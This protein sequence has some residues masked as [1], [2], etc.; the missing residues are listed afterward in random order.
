MPIKGIYF[1]GFIFFVALIFGLSYRNIV[2]YFIY[3]PD[4]TIQ[5]NPSDWQLNYQEVWFETKDRIKLHGWFFP[6]SEGTPVILF[7]HGNAGNMSHR[8]ENIRILLQHRLSVFIFDYR[9]YG[10]SEG[11]PS[12][13]GLYRDGQAAYDH[14][15]DALGIPPERIIL[16]GRSLGA[17]VAVDLSLEKETKALIIES[18]FTSTRDM[19]K[20]LFLFKWIAPLL[21]TH[22]NNLEKITR[23]TVPKL[24]IHGEKDKIVPFS[25]GQTLFRAALQPKYFLPL[26]K[27]GHNN[28][29]SMD[30]ITYFKTLANFAQALNI[31][32]SMQA[33]GVSF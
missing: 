21:P 7:C 33:V 1:M 31:S 29:W 18:A 26:R 27:A 30:E 32:Y 28:T 5:S 25:M 9:G 3:F 2:S 6:L 13:I 17:A 15:V 22:F 20:T 4:S 14:M 12:E 24:I 16:F 23:V 10:R 11:K 8:L 19:A